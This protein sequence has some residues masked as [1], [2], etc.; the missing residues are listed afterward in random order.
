MDTHAPVNKKASKPAHNRHSAPPYAIFF[1]LSILKHQSRRGT[2]QLELLKF[3]RKCEPET[4]VLGD[5]SKLTKRQ[6]EDMCSA[7]RS[8]EECIEIITIL[9]QSCSMLKDFGGFSCSCK[10]VKV[11]KQGCLTYRGSLVTVSD[12]RRTI[13]EIRCVV[14]S[15]QGCY[16]RLGIGKEGYRY[17]LTLWQLYNACTIWRKHRPLLEY[18]DANPSEEYHYYPEKAL[19][20]CDFVR[21]MNP[22]TTGYEDVRQRRNRGVESLRDAAQP[23]TNKE[24]VK[25]AARSS[26][27]REAK[28]RKQPSNA[29]QE[30]LKTAPWRAIV[31]QYR[32]SQEQHK[33][34]AQEDG[35]STFVESPDSEK[36]TASQ[37]DTVGSG[38]ESPTFW[39][40]QRP[41]TFQYLSRAY[42]RCRRS[43][44]SKFIPSPTRRALEE[45]TMPLLGDSDNGAE[46]DADDDYNEKGDKKSYWSDSDGDWQN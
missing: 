37:D 12:I 35:S 31:D 34:E 20:V 42:H 39:A 15:I 44:V 46:A 21:E 32:E 25:S 19:A 6:L 5:T 4:F 9:D 30:Y 28:P 38:Y 10:T 14:K 2:D 3:C 40:Y 43:L 29:H 22:P 33:D 17:T 7:D 18:H 8:Q 23:K 11:T 26:T 45:D 24:N 41:K 27:L 16:K 1:A 13:F 36:E